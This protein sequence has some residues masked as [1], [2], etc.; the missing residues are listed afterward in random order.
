MHELGMMHL[1][2]ISNALP[3]ISRL[4]RTSLRKIKHTRKLAFHCIMTPLM[5]E[6]PDEEVGERHRRVRA[7]AR[8]KPHALPKYK[9]CPAV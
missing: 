6:K 9:T 3:L 7:L 4:N 5:Q 2:V 1:Y 8:Q